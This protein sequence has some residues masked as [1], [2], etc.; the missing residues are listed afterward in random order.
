LVYPL[1][2]IGSN[3]FIGSHFCR[4]W[5]EAFGISR[6]ELDLADPQ[7]HFST[8]RFKY[9]LI[10][11]GMSQLDACETNP[12]QT[13]LC[14]V[15]GTLKLGELLLQKGVCPIFCSSDAV[16]NDRLEIAPLN[17][18]GAQKALLEKEAVKLGALVIRLSKV[19]GEDLGDGTLFDEM[20][21]RLSQN[22]SIEAAED[23]IF[24]PVHIDDVLLTVA[25]CIKR[26]ARGIVNV[27]G[28]HYASRYEMAITLAKG[29]GVSPHLVKAI[30]LAD[31]KEGF[32]RA[33][34]TPLNSSFSKIAWEQGVQHVL[35]NYKQE[36]Y[37]I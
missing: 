16:F 30:Q 4:K 36:V 23:Q 29:L 22:Q 10:A 8:A 25:N 6:A 31:R 37:G 26:G 19:Y 5:P 34:N 21:G 12:Q 17:V 33:K 1:I 11:A 32:K 7:I 28:P 2:V 27:T 20:A 3:G 15:E 24:S 13:H 35:N 18:Y 14:N 9:A